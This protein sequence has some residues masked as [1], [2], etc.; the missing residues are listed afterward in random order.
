MTKK[1][2]FLCHLRLAKTHVHPCLDHFHFHF[3]EET[4][5]LVD[6]PF[7]GA[8]VS[9]VSKVSLVTAEEV[10]EV[11]AEVTITPLTAEKVS[12]KANFLT[13][14]VGNRLYSKEKCHV[15]WVLCCFNE[16]LLSC[17]QSYEIKSPPW[18]ILWFRFL[19]ISSFENI[20]RLGVFM[21]QTSDNSQLCVDSQY[22]SQ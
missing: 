7:L 4:V 15:L 9:T 5:S 18:T 19:G 6:L 1:T 10:S 20:A 2:I 8:T 3:V 13:T 17:P 16:M 12:I 22:S 11:L 14:F 21:F